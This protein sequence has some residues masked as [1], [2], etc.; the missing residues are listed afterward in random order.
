MARA[1]ADEHG[2]PV[3]LTSADKKELAELRRK[4][5]RLELK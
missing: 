2:S 3:K 5:R 4:T 1:D